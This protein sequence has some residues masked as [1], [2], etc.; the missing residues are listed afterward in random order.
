MPNKDPRFLAGALLVAAFLPTTLGAQD[1]PPQVITMPE[2]LGGGGLEAR[3][4]AQLGTIDAFD[5]FYF[6]RFS[7]RRVESGIDFR[8]RVVDDAGKDYKADHYDHGNG[9]V[10]ADVDG[11]GLYDL[12]F[13]TQVGENQLW[14]SSGGGRF[15][16]ITQQAGVGVGDRIS[17]TASFADFDN[18][19]DPDLFVTTVRMGNL[20]FENLGD[21]RFREQTVEAGVAYTGHSSASVFFDYD[22]DG[23]LDLFVTNVGIYTGDVTG[24]H[25]YYVG[26]HDA[27]SG[28][29]YPPRTETSILYK[30]IDGKK[31][32][33]SSEAT[34]LLDGSWSGDASP[35]DLN[36]DGYP[37]LYVLNMQGDDHYYENVGGE[38]F[39]DKTAQYFPKTAWG[40]MGIKFFDY[41]NDGDQDLMITDMHSDMS[42]DVGAEREKDKSDMKWPAEMIQGGDNNVFGNAFYRNLGSGKLQEVSDELG[43]ENYWPWGLSVGD[44][45]ADGFEDVFVSS[46]MNFPFRYGINSVYLNNNGKVFLDSEFLLQVEPRKNGELATPWFELDCDGDDENHAICDGRTGRVTVQA[47]RGTR[48]SVIFDLDDDGDLDIVTGEFNAPP[49]ILI[50]DLAEQTDV[51]FLKIELVGTQSNRDGLGA[52]V[53]VVTGDRTLHQVNDGQSGYLSQSS[54]PLYFG[55]GEAKVVD[56]VEVDWPSGVRQVVRQGIETNR[57]IEIVEPFQAR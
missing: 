54:L 45:N 15:T 34:G 51:R 41:D 44:L 21:G 27:F 19:G 20:L 2:D 22:R 42:E 5:T 26:F 13:V 50:S 35:T 23:L 55:L 30:N 17:V 9:V 16:N 32:L 56:R 24:A 7:D 38:S 47:S 40:A 18:D 1:R 12:Y 28:H 46:S 39:V 53:R 48:S 4:R 49:Q 36:R 3:K 8:H 33:D 31:F 6:F 57:L 10:V 14:K 11:D 29:L 25:G 37:D 43:V 52:T